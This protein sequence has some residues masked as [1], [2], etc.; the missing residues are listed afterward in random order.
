MTYYLQSGSKFSV[1]DSSDI[2][3]ET[4]LKPGTYIVEQDPRTEEFFLRSM[5]NVTLSGKIYGDMED[6]VNRVLTSFNFRSGNTGIL[7]AGEKGSG[8]TLLAK[9]ISIKAREAGMPTIVI[10]EPWV[11]DTFNKFFQNID[12]PCVVLFDEFEK[13][14]DSEDQEKILTLLDGA[15]QSH[16][17]FIVTCN[18]MGRIDSHLRNRPGR[19]LYTRQFQGLSEEMILEFC[20]DKSVS[21]RDSLEILKISRLFSDFN[22]DML[23]ALVEEGKRFSEAPTKSME[24]LNFSPEK[25]RNK[26][27]IHLIYKGVKLSRKDQ[28]PQQVD[29][30]PLYSDS[31]KL[32]F[33]PDNPPA[34]DRDDGDIETSDE[35]DITYGLSPSIANSFEE[36]EQKKLNVTVSTAS[37]S[38]DEDGDIII[39]HDKNLTVQ[40][41][42]VHRQSRDWMAF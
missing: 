34:S 8:K 4:Y 29:F 20:K 41:K 30:N 9:M 32:I 2:E 39:V 16:K 10:N 24:Y 12:Q 7:L 1:V 33:C 26:Y 28:W 40:C 6:Y 37:A 27:D 38:V 17:L 31:I 25:G 18:Q 5:D 15:F 19:I 36:K 13:V 21:E 35:D 3:V 42:K 22:F 11:G 23:T 14:Y